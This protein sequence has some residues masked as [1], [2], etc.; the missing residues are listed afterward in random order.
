[1]PAL[2]PDIPLMDQ[3]FADAAE[4]LFTRACPIETARAIHA[5]A[6]TEALW[7][8]VEESGF[9]DALVPEA[10]GGAGLTPADI[11]PLLLACG[12]FAVPVPVGETIFARAALAAAGAPPPPGP[13][14]EID[15]L[16]G[17]FVT[18]LRMAG[19]IERILALT[20]QHAADR[21][22]FGRP[23]GGFQAI[24]HQCAVLAEEA[25]AARMAAGI[26]ATAVLE[27]ARVALAKIRIG[28]AAV[29]AAGIA[30]AVQGAMGIAEESGLHLFTGQL[31]RGRLAHGGEEF[32]AA[33][34][35]AALLAEGGTALDL[36]RRALG[37]PG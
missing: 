3:L 7:Q 10:Q 18:A 37:P 35:G 22:Q 27:P 16:P 13:L 14:P 8:A 32:W 11:L 21:R 29:R 5:G 15:R 4:D 36:A 2:N 28:E 19:A 33:Q 23:I 30:H 20:L 34:L 26:A 6:P 31:H 9:L 1:M 17:A 12:R 25:H 24:Q